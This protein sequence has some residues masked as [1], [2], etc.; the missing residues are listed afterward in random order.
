[1]SATQVIEPVETIEREAVTAAPPRQ[2][3]ERNETTRWVLSLLRKP[4][5]VV[6]VVVLIVVLLWAFVP[7]VFAP[8]DP[9][10]ADISQILLP[11][12]AQHFFG[13]DEL[14]RDVFSRMVHGTS[15]SL[16]APLIAVA[17]GLFFGSAI[18][19]LAGYLGRTAD[20][21]L[22]RL[23][24]V[25]L[26]IPMLVLAMTIV[27]ALGFGSVQL[28]IGVG[29]AMIGSVARVMRAE[30]MRVRHSMFVDAERSMGARTGYI[31]VRHVLP[32]AAG[33]VLVLAVLDFVQAILAIAALSFLG[34]GA[35]PPAP[36]WGSI[37]AAGQPYLSTAWWISSLPGLA[38]AIFAVCV[39]RIAREL[40]EK[41]AR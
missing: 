3:E 33:P 11:P 21:S 19:L 36:E 29:I 38:I 32:S 18:G 35:P 25:I 13:T 28:A 6:S 1:M 15:L 27:T 23:V 7:A 22:M 9:I 17:I 34:F 4:T 2:S 39:N 41:R 40:Q 5:L 24:D 16:I 31:I 37:V 20:A 12:S 30:V 14:G 10:R 8:Y 26:A